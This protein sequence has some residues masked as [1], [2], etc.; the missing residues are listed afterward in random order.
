MVQTQ[1]SWHP[2]TS[3][4]YGHIVEV[5]IVTQGPL[6]NVTGSSDDK[7]LLGFGGEMLV[8]WDLETIEGYE[9]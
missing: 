8:I 2:K 4:R 6:F 1:Q 5:V 7:N 9:K 3:T